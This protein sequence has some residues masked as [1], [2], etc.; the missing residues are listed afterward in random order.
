MRKWL[1]L[2]SLLVCCSA[3]AEE[4]QDSGFLI[5]AEFHD[6]SLREAVEKVAGL[7]G[8]DLYCVGLEGGSFS[9]SFVDTPVEVVMARILVTRPVATWR[10]DSSAFYSSF[11][12]VYDGPY[13]TGVA[14]QS[15]LEGGNV[16]CDF[17]WSVGSPEKALEFF[18][19]EYP[20]VSFTAMDFRGGGGMLHSVGKPDD[21]LQVKRELA[22]GSRIPDPRFLLPVRV[23]SPEKVKERLAKLVPDVQF[24]VLGGTLLRADGPLKSIEQARSLLWDLD[25]PTNR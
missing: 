14:G 6:H 8:K 1:L 5:T 16:S 11:L 24:E 13:L 25:V 22:D 4:V 12:V 17:L 2:F 18:E 15:T 21:V 9:G 10:L 23:A 3:A 20:G 19:E 7:W